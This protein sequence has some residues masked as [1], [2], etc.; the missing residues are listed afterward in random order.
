MY[1]FLTKKAQEDIRQFLETA[2]MITAYFYRKS[3]NIGQDKFATKIAQTLT[4]I[5]FNTEKQTI[6]R[7]FNDLYNLKHLKGI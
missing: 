3:I 6:F 2:L 1:D 4:S 7:L 5:L